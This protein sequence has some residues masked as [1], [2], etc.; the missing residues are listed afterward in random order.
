MHGSCYLVA[1]LTPVATPSEISTPLHWACAA[2][3]RMTTHAYLCTQSC[4]LTH[5]RPDSP[6]FIT[7]VPLQKLRSKVVD[8]EVALQ[9][10]AA[11]LAPSEGTALLALAAPSPGTTLPAE[12]ATA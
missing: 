10:R 7:G 2:Q 4:A 8:D 5:T 12:P 3:P 6:F 9:E 11:A 1:F